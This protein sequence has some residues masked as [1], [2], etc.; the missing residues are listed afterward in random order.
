[1]KLKD[2]ASGYHSWVHCPEDDDLYVDAIRQSEGIRLEKKAIR[3][4]AAKRGLA[5]LCLNSMWGKLTERNDRSMPIKIKVPKYLYGFLSTP[6][7]EVSNLAFSR[8][9]VV[10]IA[11]NYGAEED[12]PSQCHTNVVI[13]SYVTAV[14]RNH[15]HCYLVRLQE[16]AIYCDTVFVMYIQPKY[17]PQMLETGDKLGDMTSEMRPLESISEF[18]SGGPK[19]YAERVLTRDGREKSV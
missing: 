5:K 10:W 17:L 8:D 19:N 7:I 15:L 16:N 12:V 4:N 9:D 14:G 1:M 3:Y 6:G 13:G 18:V 2:E 11:W